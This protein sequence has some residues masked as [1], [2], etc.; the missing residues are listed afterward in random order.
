MWLFLSGLLI[1]LVVARVLLRRKS[2]DLGKA[3]AFAS[4]QAELV[5]TLSASQQTHQ[6]VNVSVARDLSNTEADRGLLA[7]E[8]RP[9]LRG[10]VYNERLG[11]SSGD[12]GRRLESADVSVE[13]LDSGVRSHEVGRVDVYRDSHVGERPGLGRG[14]PGG[15]GPELRDPAGVSAT[16][17]SV[18]ERG[19]LPRNGSNVYDDPIGDD[20]FIPGRVDYNDRAGGDIYHHDDDEWFS[21]NTGRASRRSARSVQL[22][23]SVHGGDG[24]D[25]QRRVDGEAVTE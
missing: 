15:Y 10:S 4:V 6:A 17:L 1:G 18:D 20:H 11:A 13:R 9:D 7:R 23:T 2:Y 19:L 25:V 24:H 5:A 16:D 21:R 12:Y 8:L 3:A 22:G 14:V